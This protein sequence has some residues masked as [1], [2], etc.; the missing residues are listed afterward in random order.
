MLPYDVIET[1]IQDLAEEN[2]RK[3]KEA[4]SACALTCRAFLHPSRTHL[5]SSINFKCDRRQGQDHYPNLIL[6]N[7]SLAAHCRT[8]VFELATRNETDDI[9]GALLQVK[10]MRSF[11]LYGYSAW[12]RQWKEPSPLSPGMKQALIH[13]FGLPSLTKVAMHLGGPFGDVGLPPAILLSYCRNLVDLQLDGIHPTFTFA[14]FTSASCLADVGPP[15]RLLSLH[16]SKIFQFMDMLLDIRR[17]DGLPIVDLSRLQRLIV[18]CRAGDEIERLKRI[19]SVTRRLESL[20][21][22]VRAYA[23]FHNLA[24]MLDLKSLTTLKSMQLRFWVEHEKP[25]HFPGLI[26]ELEE[27]SHQK[28]TGLQELLLDLQIYY[29]HSEFR[30]GIEWKKLDDVLGNPSAFPCLH[31]FTVKITLHTLKGHVQY[32]PQCQEQRFKEMKTRQLTRLSSRE[33]LEFNFGFSNIFHYC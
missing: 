20:D 26:E 33:H 7:P 18:D 4:L 21:C 23:T 2:G 24:Q 3:R 14:T 10:N 19:L 15:P 27:M 12:F 9:A 11:T 32:D 25:D 5:F 6:Q 29:I 16:I 13:L 1:I 17:S 8:L 31:S 30:F 28:N 22:Q